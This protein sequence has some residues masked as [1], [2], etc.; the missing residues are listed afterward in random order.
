MQ[1]WQFFRFESKYYEKLNMDVE[2][3]KCYVAAHPG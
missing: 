3:V 2:A 1:F